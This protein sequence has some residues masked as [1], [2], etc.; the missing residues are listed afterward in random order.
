MQEFGLLN[1]PLEGTNLIEASAGTGKT[2][3]IAALFLRLLVEKNLAVDEIL[4]VTFTEAAT[5][6]LRDRIRAKL[7]EATW[8]FASGGSEDSFLHELV[9]RQHD[10][11]A[12]LNRLRK[13]LHAFDL[14]S[15]FTIHG[16]CLR[17]LQEKAFESGTLFDTELITDQEHLKRQIVEDF[18]RIHFYRSSPLFVNYAIDNRFTPG[19]LRALLGNQ[20]TQPYLKIIPRTEI[21]DSSVQESD[22]RDCWRKVREAWQMGRAEVEEILIHHEGL[23]RNKYRK[24]SI[25]LWT[26]KMVQ[27][28]SSGVKNPT[29]FNEFSKFT[30]S[31]LR[32]S[33]KSGHQPPDHP[34][35]ELC[36]D[37]REIHEELQAI[38]NQRLLGLKAEL[39][40]Y[41]RRE[42][43]KRKNE[44]N[45]QSFDDLLVR[46]ERALLGDGGPELARAIRTKF[47]AAL[48]DEFQD[49][50]PVQYTIFKEVFSK[51]NG[52]LFL[53]G[54]PKQ[55]IY[56]FRGADIFAYMAAAR[57]VE[58]H[59]TLGENWRSEADLVAATNAIFATG[60]RPFVYEDIGFHLAAPA[61][62]MDTEFLELAEEPGQ[63]LQLWFL[64]AEKIT[65]S[66]KPIAKELARELIPKTVAMEISRLLSLGRDN[67]AFLGR[68]PLRESDIA[69]LVRTHKE[70]RL[71]QQALAQINIP[72]VLYSTASL[73]ESHEAMEVERVLAAIAEPHTER[74]IKPALV[75]D[76]VGIRGEELDGLVEDDSRWDRWLVTFRNYH[77]LW[78]D[79]GFI[80]MFNRFLSE[81]NVLVRLMSFPDGERRNTNMLHLAEVLHQ[82]TVDGKL[83]MSGVL[84]YL[85]EQRTADT[86]WAEEHQ[87]RL[88]SDE[89][90]VK[91]VTIHRC[92][93]LEYPIVF[94]P[95]N[96]EG[97]R[98]RNPN[99][100]FMFHNEADSM[101]LTLDLGSPERETH[102]IFAEKEQLAEN[103][104][105][106]YVALTRA[107][108]RC[109]LVWGRFNQG[110]TSAPAYLFHYPGQEAGGNIVDAT[111]ERFKQLNDRDLLLELKKLQDKSNGSILISEMAQ[112]HGEDYPPPA[113]ERLKLSCRSFSG[114]I[115]RQWQISSFSA[116]ISGKPFQV[117]LGDRDPISVEDP[118]RIEATA[119]EEETTGIFSFPKGTKAGTFLHDLLE[120]LDFCQ[121]DSYL[122]E[123]LVA[124]KLKEYGFEPGWLDT[125]CD[126]IQKVLAVP[127]IQGR[128]D[129][130]LSHIERNK[131]LSELE[132]YFPLKPFAPGRLS[133]LFAKHAGPGLPS[134]FPDRIG[135]L[136]FAPVRGFMR[137]FIDMAFQF[138]DR[139]YIVDWKSNFLGSRV[140]DYSQDALTAVM[141]GQ[142]Y[143]LQYCLYSLALHQYL[144]FR[145]PG[146][147][148]ENHFGGV[149]YIFLRGVDPDIGPSYGIYRDRPP[150]ELV[151]ALR[152]HLI[153]HP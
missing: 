49:T 27:F 65:E 84:K 106:F 32:A 46:L 16:F 58:N 74:L 92:K 152:D 121:R 19:R 81:L 18:W 73:F 54:D 107:R 64:D 9:Q 122:V 56:G 44:K 146:Y 104:R 131:R 115:D 149:F 28:L 118:K 130:T 35:F 21:P 79:Q 53:I 97:S 120:H 31:E 51:E 90:A 67:K 102:R 41:V 139:F 93:G 114:E 22:Y 29:L 3:T 105:L 112:V 25:P 145:I 144:N 127:L 83:G 98:L 80:V 66:E 60:D 113:R 38:F 111:A 108:N 13:S 137:G 143:V 7:R 20:A 126:T 33:V 86:R 52:I 85:A 119:I 59:Y 50:D 135:R 55:A 71:M 36:E 109:Y 37:L 128:D 101:R 39:F 87:L 153:D 69:V 117:E 147:D 30:T 110:E 12:S 116:L 75:T 91:L 57:Q 103:M 61:A 138:E 4:V 150:L 96:W 10:R 124:D 142:L 72:S 88:E 89:T 5:G 99:D 133:N 70:A 15:I 63:P 8:A 100:P 14:A 95:F 42:L 134:N 136:Q 48:I 43:A 2:Y 6:E 45:V 24:A 77:E 148:Y 17:V 76:M 23:N 82:A 94:C 62:T 132:F 140:Q 1:S 78:S 34:F 40:R 47:K 151:E 26:G 123:R 125:L 11:T 141:E 129:F 68:R